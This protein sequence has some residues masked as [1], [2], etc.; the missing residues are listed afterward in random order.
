MVKKRGKVKSARSKRA[1]KLSPSNYKKRVKVVLKNLTT[2]VVLFLIFIGL[3][4]L[5][6]NQLISDLLWILALIAGVISVA[7]VIAYFVV[8]FSKLIRK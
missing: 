7:L 4:Y 8:L 1:K 5:I 2:F 3:D 6:A